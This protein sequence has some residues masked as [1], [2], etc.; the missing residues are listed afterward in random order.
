L[1]I[2]PPLPAVNATES[3]VFP[4]VTEVIVGALEIDSGVDAVMLS[5]ALPLPRLFTARSWT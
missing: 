2:V 1:V 3:V 4:P 5:V